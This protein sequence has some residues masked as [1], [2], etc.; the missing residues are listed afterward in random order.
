MLYLLLKFAYII[1]LSFLFGIA[2]DWILQKYTARPDRPG[3]FAITAINGLMIIGMI[4]SYFSLVAPLAVTCNV[5]L[6]ATGIGIAILLRRHIKE[7]WIQY[8]GQYKTAGG[9]AFL[10][11]ILLTAYVL[12][13]SA[14]Q[15][16]NYDEGLYYAPFIKWIQTYRVVPG[17]ANLH[18]RFGFNSHWHLLAAVFNWSWLTGQSGN[19]L[20]GVLYLLV[21]V[22]LLQIFRHPHIQ[23]PHQLIMAGILL[24]INMPQ[25][26]VYFI[27]APSA[28]LV[29][30]Y[31][32]CLLF[33]CWSQQEHISGDLR[34]FRILAP[35]FLVTVKVS[36]M[37]VLLL[38]A[39]A[40]WQYLYTRSWTKAAAVCLTGIII[41][42]PW[43]IRNVMLSGYL[44]FPLETI[45]ICQVD[46]KSPAAEIIRNR[47]LV[48]DCAYVMN[49]DAAVLQAGAGLQKMYTWFFHNLR[50]YDK[51][52]LMGFVL[53]PI[54][55]VYH[56]RRLTRAQWESYS[57]LWIGML[58]WLSQAPD[59]RFAYG[60]LVP[61]TVWA[62]ALLVKTNKSFHFQRGITVGCTLLFAVIT[63]YYITICTGSSSA[64][65]S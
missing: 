30:F 23:W 7:R 32:G 40:T 21:S 47:S 19:Q 11:F 61:G 58:F 14:L 50:L 6:G 16:I 27:T 24:L 43:I 8:H 36:S 57:Y 18:E 39:I 29:I 51:L 54:V 25:T 41:L 53:S 20:N 4:C 62:V 28:D 60:Y 5:L 13:L 34:I 35:F 26:S 37:P 38:P 46:W 15:S 42:T 44:L 1:L 64:E 10:F 52:L 65:A 31:F 48:H 55:I 2:S 45:D 17:L 9:W 56:H 22:Y 3:S 33:L 59:P 12:Y 49:K 63:L